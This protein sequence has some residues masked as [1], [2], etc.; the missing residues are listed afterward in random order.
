MKDFA[1]DPDYASFSWFV[2]PRAVD[3]VGRVRRG[4]VFSS[5]EYADTGNVPSFSY[6]AGADAYEQIRFLESGYENRYVLDSSPK[7]SHLQLVGRR[8]ASS[9]ATSTRSSSSPRPS[10]SR[11]ARR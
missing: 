1:S 5:D 10:R 11:A 7:S 3:P 8:R 9:I 6:D 2:N 4:Y